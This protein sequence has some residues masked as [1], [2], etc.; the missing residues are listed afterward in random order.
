[1]RATSTAGK[2]SW[3]YKLAIVKKKINRGNISSDDPLFEETL[4][5]MDVEL[6]QVKKMIISKPWPFVY[7]NEDKRDDSHLDQK[8]SPS[9]LN[10]S[11]LVEINAE[12]HD[13]QDLNTS[14][15][16]LKYERPIL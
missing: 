7:Q 9:R 12:N 13:E 2:F 5:S 1:M 14:S 3:K 16:C 6:E 11:A 10:A 8:V 4:L 15:D